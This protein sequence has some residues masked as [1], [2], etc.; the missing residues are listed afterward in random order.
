M[1]FTFL[2]MAGK[3]LFIR[4]DAERAVWTQEEMS[5]DLE[6]PFVEDKVVS[7]GQRVFFK[8]PSTGNHQI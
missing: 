8:D 4:E 1:Q 6:F 2:D 7:I 3:T 5:L